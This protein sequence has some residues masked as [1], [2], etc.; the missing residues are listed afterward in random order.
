M[1]YIEVEPERM[2]SY[3]FRS[4]AECRLFSKFLFVVSNM[5]T[6][7]VSLTSILIRPYRTYPPCNACPADVSFSFTTLS[8]PLFHCDTW[9]PGYDKNATTTTTDA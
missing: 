4:F 7:L 6:L 8:F 3:L 9:L 2:G 5:L 1:E